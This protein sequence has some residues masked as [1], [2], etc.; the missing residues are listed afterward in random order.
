MDDLSG[1]EQEFENQF[2]GEKE[3]Y[4]RGSVSTAYPTTL[5]ECRAREFLSLLRD[6]RLSKSTRA[7]TSEVTGVWAHR[8]ERK[9]EKTRVIK[10]KYGT[11]LNTGS[12]S[13]ESSRVRLYALG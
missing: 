13:R 11:C 4:V 1:G 10:R 3:R 7:R 9:K 6:E 5:A 2:A 12:S 8:R